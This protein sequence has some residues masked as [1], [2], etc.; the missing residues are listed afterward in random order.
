MVTRPDCSALLD[1]FHQHQ[2]HVELAAIN[3]QLQSILDSD[4]PS[5]A[6]ILDSYKQAI[7]Y[8]EELVWENGFQPE[9]LARL[10]TLYREYEAIYATLTSDER[11]HFV[12]VIP[13]ADRP[14]HLQHCLNSIHELCGHFQY[15]GKGTNGQYSKVDVI[16]ADDS[17]DEENIKQHRDLVEHYNNLGLRC[18]H[19]DQDAQLKTLRS[20]Q[21][22]HDDGLTRILGNLDDKTMYHKGP[23]V[24]R[25]LAYLR[26]NSLTADTGKRLFYF[27]DSDQEFKV[28]VYH[29]DKALEVYGI[30]YFWHLD[31]IF[32]TSGCELLTGK[33]VG[34]PPVSP[35]V[36]A[37][38]LLQDINHVL[39][40]L[41]SIDPEQACQF[42]QTTHNP[43]GQAAYH[44]MADKFGFKPAAEAFEYH[45]PLPLPHHNVDCLKAFTYRLGQFFDGA[46]PT[47]TTDYTYM[48][49]PESV[50]AARTVYT[51]NYVFTANA[52][53]YFIPFAALRL[54]MAGPTLGRLL[55]SLIDDRF[56]TAN[57]PMLHRRT[58]RE[59]GQSEFRTGIEREHLI[60]DLSDE[61]RRQFYG[62]VM[63]FSMEELIKRGYPITKPEE[64]VV[65]AILEETS[66]ALKSIY[67]E[68]LHLVDK[69]LQQLDDQLENSKLWWNQDEDLH[70][71]VAQLTR[72]SQNIRHNFHTET[73]VWQQIM[74]DESHRNCID[75]MTGEIVHYPHDLD[76]WQ[77]LLKRH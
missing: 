25:N 61:Y 26:L 27:I 41:S 52:L 16:I 56:C 36:M 3:K 24:M 64:P 4:I 8:C 66:A 29:H 34:D 47:R 35:A 74:D 13:V 1:I 55:Q 71:T 46:H 12:I 44:D 57:L 7:P 76:H 50:V 68:K 70:E 2:D 49:P 51:G 43:A 15:G 65:K 75:A 9:L 17:K 72:F 45:C 73:K 58:T 23:S 33:V 21:D 19:F 60:I 31:R 11:Y 48:A 62:D 10:H 28:P 69:R 77:Q 20:Y 6:E 67:R 63:L 54:R 30:N 37:A 59:T 5:A 53:D 32:S 22:R 14:L 18:E 39:S 42:H 38:N 40:Q